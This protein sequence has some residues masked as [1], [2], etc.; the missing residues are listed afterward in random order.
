M[1]FL[2]KLCKFPLSFSYQRYDSV[3]SLLSREEEEMTPNTD[4]IRKVINLSVRVAFLLILNIVGVVGSIWV[5]FL[6]KIE[7]EELT[8]TRKAE[9]F[10][11]LFSTG[12]K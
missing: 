10:S 9:S 1:K 11:F 7:K 5:A 3:P 4:W 2:W 8:D 6:L 12:S